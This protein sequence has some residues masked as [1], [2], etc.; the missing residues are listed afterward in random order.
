MKTIKITLLSVQIEAIH[1]IKREFDILGITNIMSIEKLIAIYFNVVGDIY[2]FYG[3]VL[4][5]LE[6]NMLDY[7]S[8]IR[9]KNIDDLTI[10]YHLD[11]V[12]PY[13]NDIYLEYADI[14]STESNIYRRMIDSNNI[15]L[16]N[17]FVL[18]CVD[19]INQHIAEM[20]NN[21]TIHVH[22]TQ[23]GIDVMTGINRYLTE[24][25]Y[26]E[27]I[28]N[29]IAMSSLLLNVT[30]QYYQL[31]N[32]SNNDYATHILDNNIQDIVDGLEYESFSSAGLSNF[33]RSNEVY[34]LYID[35][36]EIIIPQIIDKFSKQELIE[37]TIYLEAASLINNQLVL[38]Y[39][40]E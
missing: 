14:I 22:I 8:G 31:I 38:F 17:R 32:G 21:I 36:L 25:N 40:K 33:I 5:I 18:I 24:T 2:T 9:R 34:S 29:A 10:Q 23:G 30:S 3:E 27:F 37:G 4:S 11:E 13:L 39:V 7:G 26:T 15:T 16:V 35:I 6:H 12:V 20:D 1:K 19:D 28:Y